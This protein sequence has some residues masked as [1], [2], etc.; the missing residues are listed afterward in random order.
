MHLSLKIRTLL[1]ESSMRKSKPIS[2]GKYGLT[3]N[4]LKYVFPDFERKKMAAVR[5][6]L[7][8][9]ASFQHFSKKKRSVIQIVTINAPHPSKNNVK[10]DSWLSQNWEMNGERSLHFD[11]EIILS[12]DGK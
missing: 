12:H 6:L 3:K 2:L 5:N 7:D 10:L 11:W 4:F 1:I 8:H 9:L